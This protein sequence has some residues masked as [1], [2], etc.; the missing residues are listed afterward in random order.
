MAKQAYA[1]DLFWDGDR[2]RSLRQAV[3]IARHAC[4]KGAIHAGDRPI[5][6]SPALVVRYLDPKQDA[7][8][9][10]KEIVFRCKPRGFKF[11]KRMRHWYH[12][13]QIPGR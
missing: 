12:T 11:N 8:W 3:K 2:A 13:G 1:F 7:P 6:P 5:G 9:S 10:P 4:T